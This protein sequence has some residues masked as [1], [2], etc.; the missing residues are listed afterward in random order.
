[1][2]NEP[3]IT[4]NKKAEIPLSERLKE[5]RRI[6]IERYEEL[7]TDPTYQP[8]DSEELASLQILKDGGKVKPY[9]IIIDMAARVGQA[10]GVWAM[11]LKDLAAVYDELFLNWRQSGL[12]NYDSKEWEEN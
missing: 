4:R 1:M 2:E 3:R 12:V 6:F 9:R 10:N 8:V 7:L 5:A 11:T